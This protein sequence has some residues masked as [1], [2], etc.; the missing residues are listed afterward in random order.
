MCRRTEIAEFGSCVKGAGGGVPRV[1]IGITVGA[2]A[3]MSTARGSGDVAGA[4][5]DGSFVDGVGGAFNAKV[6]KLIWCPRCQRW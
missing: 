6:E 4:R 3:F 2:V 5:K 1:Q